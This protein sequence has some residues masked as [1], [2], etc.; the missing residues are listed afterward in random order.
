MSLS[1][2]RLLE[3]GSGRR[4]VV[5][6]TL[7]KLLLMPA[8]AFILARFVFGM[9]GHELFAIVVLAALPTA[10]NVFNYAQRYERGVIIARDTVL[11]TTVLCIPV[12]VAI[13]L[14]FAGG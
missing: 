5:L 6:A 13:A 2:S 10:Q 11:L 1:S 3:P 14:L 9:T 12:L 8:V 7:L 4:D